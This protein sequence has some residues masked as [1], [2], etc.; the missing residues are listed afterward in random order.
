[1]NKPKQRRLAFSLIEVTL[2]IGIV[3]TSMLALVGLFAV[4]SRTNSAA[5]EQ[6]AA[7]DLIAAVAADLRATPSTNSTSSQFAIAI[8]TNTTLYFDSKGQAS[9]SIGISSRYQVVVTFLSNGG[10][11]KTATFVNL[12][13]TWPAVASSNLATTGAVE[14]FLALDRN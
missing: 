3:A 1:M 12:R 13:A 6:T 14:S 10:G 5:G 8:P 4:G 7:T 9:T 11:S 2:A